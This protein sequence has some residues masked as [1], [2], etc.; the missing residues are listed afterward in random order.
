VAYSIATAFGTF[1]RPQQRMPFTMLRFKLGELV[2][3]RLRKAPI[4]SAAEADLAGFGLNRA[5]DYKKSAETHVYYEGY[6]HALGFTDSKVLCRNPRSGKEFMKPAIGD[7]I[8]AFFEAFRQVNKP[9]FDALK[10]WLREAAATRRPRSP[11]LD[12]CGM[13]ADWSQ[14]G[15][16]FADL[17][18]QIHHGSAIREDELFWHSD[19]ENS[20]L[21]LGLSVRGTRV[22]HSKRATSVSGSV[23]D[24]LETQTGDSG[25]MYVSSSSL[26]NHAPE[27]PADISWEERIVAVQARLLYTTQML[28]D[29]RSNRTDAAWDSMA[30]ILA[31]FLATEPLAVPTMNDVENALKTFGKQ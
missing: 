12:I 7:F 13:L 1:G 11:E 6:F 2:R 4:F 15:A 14:E 19:A 30:D 10:W 9:S 23:T 16:Y 28:K 22:L 25:D 17:S 27:Y 24:T 3:D 29:F 20:L 26:V 21:H 8:R 31:S 5:V 18:E